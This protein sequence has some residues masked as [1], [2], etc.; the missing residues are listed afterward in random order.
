MERNMV[1]S[2]LMLILILLIAPAAVGL[3]PAFFLSP[4]RRTPCSIF[5]FGSVINLALMQLVAVPFILLDAYGFDKIV[6]LYS[7]LVGIFSIAGIVLTVIRV[8][9]DGKYLADSMFKR[10][11][12]TEEVVEWIMFV[13]VLVFQLVMFI[14]MASFDG[15]DAYYVVES[16]LSDETGTLYRIR[17]YTGLSTGV[18]LRHA[19]AA[20]TMWIAYIA[21]VSGLHSTIVAHSI[22]GLYLIPLTYMVYLETGRSLLP[23]ERKK[24]PIFL[25]FVGIMQ[26]FGNVSIY[27][28]ATF[29]LTRTWQGKSVLVNL[30]IPVAFWLLLNIFDTESHENDLRLGYWVMLFI[31]NIVAAMC[32]TTSVLLLAMLIGISGL[33]L[34]IKN[35]DLQILLKLIITCVP[36]VVYGCLYLLV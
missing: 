33:V 35:R 36:L 6:I 2:I 11:I 7:I 10:D 8:K 32:S 15:D 18:D 13:L 31:N 16:L 12:S 29:F 19:L 25:I 1:L 26:I 27:T 34:T 17:P 22:I 5:I 21:R 4:Q 9:K 23:K 24:L 28:G 20:F 14:R 30:V 3:L